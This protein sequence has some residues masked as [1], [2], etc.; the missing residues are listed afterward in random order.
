MIIF[1]I[2][3]APTHGAAAYI[4]IADPYLSRV[5]TCIGL[6][7]SRNEKVTAET[8]REMMMLHTDE[9]LNQGDQVVNRVMYNKA[10]NEKGYKR[11]AEGKDQMKA[12]PP[13]RFIRRDS[14]AAAE[15]LT[16][17]IS[18]SGTCA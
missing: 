11:M 17:V 12:A 6:A 5:R 10:N 14:N 3:A 1:W 9:M 16:L 7:C 4:A 13:L 18:R 2:Q 8:R 15:A